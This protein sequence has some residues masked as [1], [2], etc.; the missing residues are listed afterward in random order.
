MYVPQKKKRPIR[1]EKKPEAKMRSFFLYLE[2]IFVKKNKG[3][4]AKKDDRGQP[5]KYLFIDLI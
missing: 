5:N 3:N 2:L 1:R 4:I